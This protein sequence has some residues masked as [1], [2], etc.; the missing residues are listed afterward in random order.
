MSDTLKI[1][2][3]ILASAR[4]VYLS[5]RSLVKPH[6]HGFSR[7]SAFEFILALILL[8]LNA[9]FTSPDPGTSSSRGSC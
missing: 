5:R 4:I 6:S 3:F 8:N 7:F 9:W 1:I 2:V